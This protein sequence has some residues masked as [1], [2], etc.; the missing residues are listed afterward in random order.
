[1]ESYPAGCKRQPVNSS[2]ANKSQ[3]IE[4]SLELCLTR[5]LMPQAITA[6]ADGRR[7]YSGLIHLFPTRRTYAQGP[8][9]VF[10]DPGLIGQ[11]RLCTIPATGITVV[12]GPLQSC[13][14][15]HHWPA[16]ASQVSTMVRD[17]PRIAHYQVARLQGWP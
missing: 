16:M 3:R 9:E 15:S 6:D 10:A 8:Q 1:M 4:S 7:H 12:H 5:P 2:M 11:D 13:L 14:S 17:A